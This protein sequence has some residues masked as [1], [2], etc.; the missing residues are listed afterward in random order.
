MM[1]RRSSPVGGV[2]GAYTMAPGISNLIFIALIFGAMWFLL[3]RPQQQR[4]KAQ[5]EMLSKLEQGNEVITIGGIY[6]T[7]V[8]LG[9]ERARLQ[10]A[11][12]SEFEIARR[13]VSSVV[14]KSEI[15]EL[16]ALDAAGHQGADEDGAAIASDGHVGDDA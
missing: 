5:A 12:G 4:A 11:D 1:G 7:I 14:K 10:V 15:E 6:G 9:D 8:D 16:E 13:A 3:I 2:E